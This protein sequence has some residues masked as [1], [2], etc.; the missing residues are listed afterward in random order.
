VRVVGGLREHLRFF[1][2][3]DPA[4]TRK[5]D[6]AGQAVRSTAKLRVVS[7]EPL[8]KTMR[9]YDITTGTEDF[10]AN[11]VVSHNCY[12]RPSH[13][14]RGLSPGLDFETRLFY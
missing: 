10:I 6:I 2:T 13:A 9:L 7:V 4:I 1:H 12:A 5:R 8:G 14:Y 3:M 11:G